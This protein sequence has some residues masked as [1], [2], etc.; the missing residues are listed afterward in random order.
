MPAPRLAFLYPA[1]W[2][3]QEYYLFA[4]GLDPS[5]AVFMLSTRLYGGDRD[6]D[7]ASLLQS[8]DPALLAQGARKAVQLRPDSLIWACT[9]ASFVGGRDWA[10]SQVWAM[11]AA[12]TCPASSTSLAFEDG[13]NALGVTRVAIMATYPAAVSERFVAF[14]EAG[15]TTVA[16][17]HCL[18]VMSGWDA[19]Q[20][21]GSALADAVKAADHPEAEAILVPDTA[22]AT[23][24]LL[25]GLEASLGKPVLSANQVSLWK[26]LRLAGS[27]VRPSG[28]GRLFGR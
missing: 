21:A 11:E 8:G 20:L 25:A 28:A 5:P 17:L 24:D 19:G 3:D 16:K 18:D 26:A 13:L 7:V 9:S 6:H 10:V 2:G 4:E 14:I 1:G 22:V 27:D 23:L 15:G 12:G